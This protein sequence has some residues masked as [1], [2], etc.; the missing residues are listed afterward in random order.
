MQPQM[1]FFVSVLFGFIAWGVVVAVYVW[2]QLRDL[3]RTAALRPLLMLHSFRFAG[4]AFMIPGVVSPELPMAFAQRAAYGDFVAAV[5]AL[6]AL[7]PLPGRL[8]IAIAW[9][10]N[11][12]GGIDLL[13][14]FYAGNQVGLAAGAGQL[15][16]AY[17]IPTVYVPLLFITHGLMFRLLLRHE[18][19]PVLQASGRA[20]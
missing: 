20:A 17:F 19:Q 16:A 3:P 6:L 8:G 9:V 13:A 1:L 2:P 14:A 5:L 15:G 11:V 7:A 10:M 12:W 4:L 18:N